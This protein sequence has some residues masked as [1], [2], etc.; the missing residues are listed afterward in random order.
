MC[1]LCNEPIQSTQQPGLVAV[2]EERLKSCGLLPFPTPPMLG[3]REPIVHFKISRGTLVPSTLRDRINPIPSRKRAHGELAASRIPAALQQPESWP[4]RGGVT[5]LGATMA[6]F[7]TVL[8]ASHEADVSKTSPRKQKPVAL[9]SRAAALVSKLSAV[10][11]SDEPGGHELV[12]GEDEGGGR[13][14]RGPPMLSLASSCPFSDT[15][16]T[17][18]WYAPRDAGTRYMP[19]PTESP[20]YGVTRNPANAGTPYALQTAVYATARY[21]ALP[22]T[23]A[24]VYARP[25]PYAMPRYPP[26]APAALVYAEPWVKVHPNP[27]PK[28]VY[29]KLHHPQAGQVMQVYPPMAPG[30]LDYAEPGDRVHPNHS[31][32]LVY[33]KLHH[34]QAGQVMPVYQPMAPAALVYPEP[35]PP[36]RQ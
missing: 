18:D 26:M 25:Y 10:N 6:H 34:P 9:Q 8:A 30:A 1:V 19:L 21:G 35:Y 12:D 22:P 5:R 14:G 2:T 31:P 33:A 4:H 15:T 23:A 24:L 27:S 20:K 11:P 36:L 16:E 13:P 17:A 3:G 28:L 32:T 7:Q 29:A